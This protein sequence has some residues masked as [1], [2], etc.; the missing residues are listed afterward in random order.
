MIHPDN[1]LHLFHNC[2]SCL[3]HGGPSSHSLLH[4][5]HNYHLSVTLSTLLFTSNT[6]PPAINPDSPL[7]IRCSVLLTV[8]P[9]DILDRL[10]TIFYFEF[11]LYF[12]YYNLS[13]GSFSSF[14]YLSVIPILLIS[15]LFFILLYSASS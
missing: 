14:K 4:S 6:H 2:C 1:R 8:I 12:I 10:T 15:I 11:S 5:V 13:E 3:H 7:I 9:P